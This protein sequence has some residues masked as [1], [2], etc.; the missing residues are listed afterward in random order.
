MFRGPHPVSLDGKGRLAIPTRFRD[1]LAQRGGAL[2]LTLSPRRH[3]MLYA[4]A[5]WEPIEAAIND[6]P[7]FHPLSQDLQDLVVGNAAELEMDGAGRILLPTLHRNFGR[8]EKDV[9]LVGKGDRFDIW[10][11][12]QWSARLDGME[13]LG[14]RM[15]EARRNGD[16]PDALRNFRF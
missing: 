14:G 2:V 9:V 10:D 16:L 8:L 3:L 6:L 4:L 13:D 11:A 7:S 12:G 15:D 1:A 5:D